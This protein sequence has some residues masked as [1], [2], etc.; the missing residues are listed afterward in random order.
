MIRRIL[1]SII[2]LSL[3]TCVF[4]Q[5]KVDRGYGQ[6]VVSDSEPAVRHN[7]A[8]AVKYG[9]K[10]GVNFSNMKNG[11]TFD[12]GFTMGTGFHFGALVNLHWGQRTASSLP[13]TGLWGLQPELMFSRQVISTKNRNIRLN[14]LK[15]PVLLKI[16]PLSALSIE[17]GPEITYLFSAFPGEV[18]FDE[19][20]CNIGACNG[21]DFGAAAGV[22]YEFRFGLLLGA[23]YSAG[24]VDLASN[25]KWKNTSNIQIYAGWLF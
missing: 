20:S 6:G 9:I 22:S 11:M 18:N 4:A 15:V 25:L 19:A 7:S 8:F 10:A 2:G 16:Y 12:P 21:F 24:F 3:V 23:R 5:V 13:G 1:I 14:S 17:V